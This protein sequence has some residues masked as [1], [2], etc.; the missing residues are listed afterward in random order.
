MKRRDFVRRTV[1]TAGALAAPIYIPSRVFGTSKRPGANDR[2]ALGIIGPGGRAHSLLSESPNDVRLVALADCDL[3]QMEKFETWAAAKCPE[4]VEGK[5]VRY[6]DYRAMFDREKLDAVIIATTTHSRALICLDAM[7]AGLDVYAE[8][9]LTLTIEEGWFLIEAEKKYRTV[10]QVGTQQRSVPIDNFASDLVKGGAIGKVH[11]VLCEN[12]ISPSP[13]P[14]LKAEPV[15]EGLNWDM[16]LHQ[17]EEVPYTSE[18]HPSLAKWGP[19]RPY[20]GGGQSHGVTGWGA[21][22]F[23]QVQRALGTDHTT[24]VEVWLEEDPGPTAKVSLRYADGPV[25]KLELSQEEAPGLG[26]VF[27]GEEGKIEINRNRAVSD[28]P[29]IVQGAPVPDN[30]DVLSSVAHHHLKNWVDCIRSREKPN[31]PAEVG[32]RSSVICHLINICR[33]LGRTVQWDPRKEDFDSDEEASSLRSRP[34]RKGYEL[35][36]PV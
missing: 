5:L 15:P 10:F 19:W 4:V 20:D 2:I 29:E 31:A 11:T 16:W 22:A 30:N 7:R 36:K 27:L 12:F 21:H 17:T 3:R 13:L 8:K 32:H 25:M 18:L 35:P 23:D 26:A 14:D 33:E 24:P 1:W 34:R 6:Q 9:P 28:P